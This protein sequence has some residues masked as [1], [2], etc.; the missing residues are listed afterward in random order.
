MFQNRSFQ[1]FKALSEIIIAGLCS[2]FR[3]VEPGE[4]RKAM[5]RAEIAPRTKTT[6]QKNYPSKWARLKENPKYD[7]MESQNEESYLLEKQARLLEM[8]QYKDRHNFMGKLRS[9]I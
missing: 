2:Q 3:G 5:S 7:W 8:L 9:P 4:I 6:T 1:D